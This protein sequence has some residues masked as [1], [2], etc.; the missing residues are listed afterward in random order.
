MT[1]ITAIDEAEAELARLEAIE[2]AAFKLETML[3]DIWNEHRTT[4]AFN[5]WMHAHISAEKAAQELADAD[6]RVRDL[7][8]A[9]DAAAGVMAL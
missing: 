1:L 8:L 6:Q 7:E 3:F 5:H 2:D 4:E 9:I